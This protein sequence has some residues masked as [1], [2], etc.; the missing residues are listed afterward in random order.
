MMF[1]RLATLGA[2]ISRRPELER[3]APGTVPLREACPVGALLL[4]D[5]RTIDKRRVAALESR[6]DGVYD[7]LSRFKYVLATPDDAGDGCEMLLEKR[8]LPGAR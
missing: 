6:V 4:I 1:A 7:A 5:V 2:E 8:A 3:H